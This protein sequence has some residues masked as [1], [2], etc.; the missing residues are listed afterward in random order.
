[1]SG[2]SLFLIMSDRRYLL[3]TIKPYSAVLVSLI[4]FS[5]VIIWNARHD[6][7][8]LRHTAGQAHLAEGFTVS[9][10]SFGEFLGS[11]AGIVTPVI[12]ILIFFALHKLYHSEK[13]YR[14]FFLTA[15]SSPSLP[16]SA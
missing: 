5:P 14:S 9:I 16:F 13:G 4:V 10:R 11:Q 1:M 6:W 15:F 8:T 2:C 3:R 7:V 12:F